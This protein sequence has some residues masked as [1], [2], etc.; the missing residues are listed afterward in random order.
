MPGADAWNLTPSSTD[1][2]S[3]AAASDGVAE[4]ENR[5]VEV[6]GAETVRPT[7]AEAVPPRPSEI[8]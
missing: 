4:A 1:A 2:L 7:V 6:E 8:A 3:F 5:L